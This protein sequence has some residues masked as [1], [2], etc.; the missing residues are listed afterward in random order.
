M[1]DI[2]QQIQQLQDDIDRLA[3][4][5]NGSITTQMVTSGG[6]LVDSVAKIAYDYSYSI[7]QVQATINLLQADVDA[8]QLIA[9]AG[10]VGYLTK[11]EMDA[12]TSR[13]ANTIGEVTNDGANNGVYVFNGTTWDAGQDRVSEIDNELAKIQ[14]QLELLGLG[15]LPNMFPNGGFVPDP[16]TGVFFDP[17]LSFNGSGGYTHEPVNQSDLAGMNLHYAL[18]VGPTETNRHVIAELP[19][20]IGSHWVIGSY[21]TYS[22]NGIAGDHGGDSIYVGKDGALG[23]GNNG[24]TNVTRTNIQLNA[25]VWIHYI[26]FKMF[27]TYASAQLWL[28]SP[29]IS[30]TEEVY[31]TGYQMTWS[32]REFDITDTRYNNFFPSE[33]LDR[34]LTLEAQARDLEANKA[35]RQLPLAVVDIN[36]VTDKY[37]TASTT[38]N[39][40]ISGYANRAGL[41]DLEYVYEEDAFNFLGEP[42]VLKATDNVAGRYYPGISVMIYPEDL[43]K[44][45]VVPDDTT[46]P[47]VSFRGGFLKKGLNMNTAQIQVFFCLQYSDTDLYP[48]YG[49][50]GENVLFINSAS[51]PSSGYLGA[52]DTNWNHTVVS[53]S[54]TELSIFGHQGVQVPATYGG[55]PFQ[56]IKMIV[57]GYSDDQVTVLDRE[58]YGFGF[59][60]IAGSTIALATP[61]LNLPQDAVAYVGTDDIN[62]ID[63]EL[64][65]KVPGYDSINIVNAAKNRFG[66]IDAQ[67][68]SNIAGFGPVYYSLDEALKE[69]N[70]D[71]N[72]LKGTYG[73]T[74]VY[75]PTVSMMISPEDLA[76]LGIVPD[77]TTPPL[78]S[79][80]A[81]WSKALATQ[82]VAGSIQVFFCIRYGSTLVHGWNSSY[83]VL[84]NTANGTAGYI[85]AG[86]TSWNHSV[87]VY[88]DSLKKVYVHKGVPLPANYN[89]NPLTGIVITLLGYPDVGVTGET[90]IGMTD[91]ALVAGSNLSAN[92]LLLNSPDD[93][94]KVGNIQRNQ[95][96]QEL[97]Q[98]LV[99]KGEGGAQ[100]KTITI[101]NS[102]KVVLLG[103]SY[104]ASHYTMK[105]KAYISRLSELTDWRLDN[106]ARSGDDYLEINQ[107]ILT[108]VGEYHPTITLKEYGATYG[109]LISFTNDTY[110]RTRDL[111]YFF[112]NVRRIA[113]SIMSIGIKP[114]LSTEFVTGNNREIMGLSAVAE[115]LGIEFIDIASNARLFDQTRYSQYWGGGHPAT[116]TNGLFYD[117]LLPYIN[118]L[119]RP[120]QSIKIFR[121]RE[122]FLLSVDDDLLYDDIQQRVKKWSEITLGHHSLVERLEPYYDR[123]VDIANDHGGYSYNNNTSEYLKLQNGEVVNFGDY[124]LIEVIL[125]ASANGVG[126]VELNI[127]DSTVEVY[128]RNTLEPTDFD[129][130]QKIQAFVVNSVPSVTPGDTYT[131]AGYTFTVVGTAIAPTGEN[132]LL[133]SN[134]VWNDYGSGTL[135]KATGTGPTSISFIEAYTGFDPDYY[136][137]LYLP[138]G[139][140]RALVNDS[141]KVTISGLDLQKAMQYDKLIFMIKKVGGFSLNHISLD[142][143]GEENKD[144]RSLKNFKPQSGTQLLGTNKFDTIGD[145]NFVGGVIQEDPHDGVL[146]VGCTKLVKVTPTKKVTQSFTFSSDAR[147]PT[148]MDFVVWARRYPTHFSP[149]AD[150]ETARIEYETSAPINSD[151]CD[152][153]LI[154]IDLDAGDP[155]AKLKMTDLVGL[156][157]Q[158][159]R[160]RVQVPCTE[161]AGN[162]LTIEISSEEELE[163][164]L[165]EVWK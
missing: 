94:P 82:H 12:D 81:G 57:L 125:P 148:E 147:Y 156:H 89:G 85:G 123:L 77:D 23:D 9:T 5:V 153:R 164:A 161:L 91:V 4:F 109:I 40:H 2:L 138:R 130:Y 133:C 64:A 135:T 152:Y 96:S 163:I 145:W 19:L 132:L 47:T 66:H 87:D 141:G 98:S 151:T 149:S 115:E 134:R 50:S 36:A 6:A 108:D 56:G 38:P 70:G 15:G 126:S 105:D 112:D 14:S 28:G 48:S 139:T 27:A 34:I 59:A 119:P 63:K 32:E 84:F 116:R 99:F 49:P 78:I 61:Y 76:D 92:T 157:W 131:T 58:L 165:V 35:D 55:K 51:S 17:S 33:T 53:A 18:K 93:Y 65:Q 29:G 127:S 1:A 46:P 137:D 13:P 117:P 106:F 122:E 71:R 158:E 7:S 67:A 155:D 114:I 75:R 129:A 95:F 110:H 62:R 103:D 86:D 22:P 21:I 26:K 8:L 128:S 140:W 102:D 124:A 107:R 45:G 69:A 25:N 68:S 43:T 100:A 150:E 121:K 88:E 111:D 39:K 159:V 146:P 44:I 52:G 37:A 3:D 20:N 41:R 113:Q 30:G 80:K 104:T 142:W 60:C 83:D 54:E 16:V 162:T 118:N 136:D 24:I 101:Q 97:E 160:L 144:Y 11:A 154:N 74:Q 120:K 31:L 90:E 72:V 42:N 10:R 143:Y 73:S 79:M